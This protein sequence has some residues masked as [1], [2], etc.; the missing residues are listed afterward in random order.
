MTLQL[1]W[2]QAKTLFQRLGSVIGLLLLFIV[3]SVLSPDFLTTGNLLTVLRQVSINALIAFGM[4][5]VILSG[6]IDLSVG[7]ILAFTGAVTAGL[8]AAGHG[9]V[10]SVG[11]GLALGLVLGMVNGALVSWGRV[12]PFIATLG[13][14]TLLRGLTLSYTQGSPIPV[15]NPGFAMLGG[16]YIANLIPL[17]VLWMAIAFILC[18]FLLRGTVFGRHVVAIGGNQEAAR[19]SGV[20]LSPMKLAIYGLSGLLSA[21]AGVVL[22]S[23]LYSAQATAGAGY[24]LDAIAAV[25][26]GGTSL[27]GGRG[28]LFGTLIGALLIGFLN[29]GLNLLGVSSFYQQVVKGI[30]ILIAVLL[31]RR[32]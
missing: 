29:N 3:L 23:R 1:N 22:T 32:Q 19:L 12:A 7:A 16:G 28:W 20:R 10:L 5:F 13:T 25:V 6:G 26:L 24:E 31:D 15:T 27:A 30:V 21:F 14:L 11:A 9:M 17:P 8:M 18:G 2:S 4:T